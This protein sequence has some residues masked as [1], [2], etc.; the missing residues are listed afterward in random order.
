MIQFLKKAVCT[1][2]KP[3]WNI[4]YKNKTLDA[5][6][7]FR[8]F[9][10][11]T[12]WT[13]LLKRGTQRKLLLSFWEGNEKDQ[14]CWYTNI[15]ILGLYHAAK[16]DPFFKSYQQSFKTFTILSQCIKPKKYK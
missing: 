12:T 13:V 3:L 1:K 7:E 6:W 11:D 10:C 4:G 8:V 9:Y 16:N 2:I 14:F 15:A 5:F